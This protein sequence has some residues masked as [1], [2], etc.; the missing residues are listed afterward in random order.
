LSRLTL[1]LLAAALAACSGE[2]PEEKARDA[3]KGAYD[4]Y[5]RWLGKHSKHP[6]TDEEIAE[7]LPPGRL[8]PWGSRY[9]MDIEDRLQPRFWSNG[10][11]RTPNTDDDIC[12]PT[13]PD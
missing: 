2:T 3:C 9:E 10:P 6:E 13:Y 11:D 5:Q 1:F 7:I 8:D 12:F 4:R